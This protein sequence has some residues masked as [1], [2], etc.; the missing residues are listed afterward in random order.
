MGRPSHPHTLT[1]GR[2]LLSAS[3]CVICGFS[4]GGRVGIPN[5]SFLIPN[6]RCLVTMAATN[7]PA[8]LVPLRPQWRGF[9]SNH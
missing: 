9:A 6:L 1:P 7:V 4:V 5:S 8:V 2:A 3:I